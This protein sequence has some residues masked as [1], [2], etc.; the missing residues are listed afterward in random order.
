MIEQESNGAFKAAV[1]CAAADSIAGGCK[2]T[3]AR[4]AKTE[5]TGLYTKLAKE[6]GYDCAVSGY[7]PLAASAEYNGKD[8]VELAC[9]NRPDGAV[10]IFPPSG[11]GVIYDC[12]HSEVA[13][14]RCG[15]TKSS[16]AYDKLTADLRTLGKTSCTVSEER[17]VGVTADKR[18]YLEVGCSDGLPGYMIEY[19]LS[20][21]APKGTTTCSEAKGI[22]GG[23][24]LPGNTK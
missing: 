12:A 13:G 8:V 10:A 19:T 22:S 3:D 20:P 18:A 9:S 15:L 5:Q 4:S 2:L 17:M 16:A 7:A 11:K 14:F 23:C 21:L 6:S 1:D 24:S